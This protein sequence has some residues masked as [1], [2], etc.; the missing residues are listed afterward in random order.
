[1]N[2]ILELLNSLWGLVS[3]AVIS[4][5][6]ILN[7]VIILGAGLLGMLLYGRWKRNTRDIIV[8]CIGIA[9]ILFS[10]GLLEAVLA[11]LCLG[12]CAMLLAS[13]LLDVAEKRRQPAC[14]RM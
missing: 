1:M 7:T 4:A 14:H 3:R 9:V 5:F 11:G 8:K 2:T 12:G 10:G 13:R 6:P